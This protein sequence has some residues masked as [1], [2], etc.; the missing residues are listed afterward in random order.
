MPFGPRKIS[1]IA[2]NAHKYWD[3]LSIPN[4]PIYAPRVANSETRLKKRQ[5]PSSNINAII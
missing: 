5:F 3:S 2:L 1:V 4:P